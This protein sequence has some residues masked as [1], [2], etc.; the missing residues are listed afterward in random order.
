[1]QSNQNDP[2][3][4]HT[5]LLALDLK[6]QKLT[7]INLEQMLAVCLS[8]PQFYDPEND[9]EETIKERIL[10]DFSLI[11]SGKSVED[12]HVIGLFH[13]DQLV[14]ILDYVTAYPDS[15]TVFIGLLMLDQAFSG[16]GLGS[17]V[18]RHLENQFRKQG[19]DRIELG[20]EKSN[21][22]SSHFWHK[23]GYVPVWEVKQQP[24]GSIVLSEKRIGS[25]EI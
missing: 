11:P 4:L 9:T 14:G 3:V 8:N 23:N 20:W 2:A 6:I 19:F 13:G 22:Q 21:P 12:K 24:D 15:R 5:G 10:S 7:P 17:A 1:M 18:I 25:E 16:H